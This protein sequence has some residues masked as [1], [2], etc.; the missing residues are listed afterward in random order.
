MV[1]KRKYDKIQ[2]VLARVSGTIGGIMIILGIIA[3]PYARKKM[4]EPLVNGMFDI[5]VKHRAKPVPEA[6]GVQSENSLTFGHTPNP[7]LEDRKNQNVDNTYNST[8]M[9]NQMADSELVLKDASNPL[10]IS[11]RIQQFIK[12]YYKYN[13]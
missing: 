12:K 2:D 9:K 8:P 7:V 5:R 4:F 1:Y 10:F 11:R 6:L 3:I 13:E